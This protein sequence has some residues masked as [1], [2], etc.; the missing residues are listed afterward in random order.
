MI[1]GLLTFKP[2]ADGSVQILIKGKAEDIPELAR[3]YGKE[4]QLG[5]AVDHATV[6]SVNNIFLSR[7]QYELEGII[8]DIQGELN[9]EE[10]SKKAQQEYDAAIEL[11]KQ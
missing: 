1:K 9:I 7:I 2:L 10:A 4:V 6:Q 11:L 8:K 5:L 3:L